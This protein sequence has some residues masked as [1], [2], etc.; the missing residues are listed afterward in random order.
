M[1]WDSKYILSQVFTILMYI[2]LAMTYY[3]KDRKKIL[4]VSFLSTISITIA[5]ILLHAGTGFAM[6][7]VAT[8]RNIIFIIDE[9][10][11]GKKDYLT[12]KDYYLLGLFYLIT[13]ILTALTYDGFL[14][15]LSV[16][17]TMIYT[18][19]VWQKKVLIYKICG[20]P[21]GIFWIAYNIYIMSVFGIALESILLIFST[22][23]FF[24]ELKE[25]KS[26]TKK[27]LIELLK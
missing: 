27:S 26:K 22:I 20:I 23:G 19:S 7:V 15:L 5:Y 8:I 12:K 25:Q 11:N 14:S 9:K 13:V 18:Y 16:F 2:L 1:N 21:V 3:L 10:K 6:C 17:A 24:K 4:I